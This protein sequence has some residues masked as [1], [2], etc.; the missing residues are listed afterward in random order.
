MYYVY[1]NMELKMLL[2]SQRNDL[3]GQYFLIVKPFPSKELANA[4][5]MGY[6][7]GGVCK[8]VIDIPQPM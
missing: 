6:M 4:F 8:G 2:I 7:Y 1:F 5:C 3:V